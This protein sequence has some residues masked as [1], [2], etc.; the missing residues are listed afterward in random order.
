MRET[1]AAV[2]VSE[3]QGEVDRFR[4]WDL[5]IMPHRKL[6]K[7]GFGLVDGTR[8]D[9][10]TAFKRD[11]HPFRIAIVCA[12]W[13]IAQNPLRT[14]FQAHYEDIVHE[15]NQEK[16]RVTIEH[17][18]EQLL[19]FVD[20][21]DE[22][23]ERAIREGLD[24]ESVAIFDLLKKPELNPKEIARIKQVAVGLLAALKAEQLRVN[25]WRDK[26]ATRDAVRS[27][28]AVAETACDSTPRGGVGVPVEDVRL[29]PSGLSATRTVLAPDGVVEISG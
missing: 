18:F 22:E 6:L 3:E 26:E 8:I 29:A 4:K 10:E 7:D 27:T 16:D 23:E 28:I 9:V 2:V 11:D 15:H 14:N 5:D 25:H 1:I 17:T 12:M 19:K 20:E 21:L 13:L 24:V